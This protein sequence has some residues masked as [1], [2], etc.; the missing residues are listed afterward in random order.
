MSNLEPE[1]KNYFVMKKKIKSIFEMRHF[2]KDAGKVPGALEAEATTTKPAKIREIQYNSELFEAR[3]PEDPTGILPATDS[4]V[5]HWIDI[6]GLSNIQTIQQ[7]GNTFD[8]HHLTLEDIINTDQLPKCE[9]TGEQ[10]FFTLKFPLYHEQT[11]A[12]E[13]RHISLILSGP[14]LLSL[15]EGNQDLLHPIKERIR[16]SQGRVRKR[17]TEY[18]LYA[19]IDYIVDQY[20]FIMDMIRDDIERTEDQLID[21]PEIDHIQKI[22]HI[23]KRIVYLRKYLTSLTKAVNQ[24]L[25]SEI[26]FSDTHIKVYLRDIYDHTLHISEAL[27]TSKDLQTNLLEMNMANVNNSMNRVMK[28]LTVVATIFIPL[29]FV[30]GIYGMNFQYMPELNW[31]YGYP[32]VLAA[33]LAI[34]LIMLWWMKRKDWL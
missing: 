32:S 25:G 30:V 22:H 2:L 14:N 4:S 9:S 21:E 34:A 31:K 12:L 27:I 33:M 3:Q 19:L 29:T 26:Q 24:L 11:D 16:Q 28:T 17:N 1:T 8:I 15:Q 20:F 23:K 6:A 5:C 13:L 10:L 7:L 18:L